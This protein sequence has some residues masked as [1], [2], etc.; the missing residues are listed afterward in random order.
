MTTPGHPA[1]C[2]SVA[3]F[4]EPTASDGLRSRYPGDRLLC[5]ACAG[6][7]PWLAHEP[8]ARSRGARAG[9]ARG[10]LASCGGG[11]RSFV[12]LAPVVG[13]SRLD[14]SQRGA[15]SEHL[16]PGPDDVLGGDVVGEVVELDTDEASSPELSAEPLGGVQRRVR[17]SWRRGSR[18]RSSRDHSGDP[19]RSAP[20]CLPGTGGGAHRGCSCAREAEEPILR[21]TVARV[22]TVE[23]AAEAAGIPV[24]QLVLT[25]RRAAGSSTR[26]LRM[27][28]PL[29]S[30]SWR[31]QRTQQIGVAWLSWRSTHPGGERWGSRSPAAIHPAE[32]RGGT[33]WALAGARR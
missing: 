29:A 21:R 14:R 33:W 12:P 25:L 7:S 30:S 6:L 17:A 10:A 24:R 16:V 9:A 27:D 22:A 13:G 3:L 19:R 15:L 23:R 1:P 18:R 28:R 5:Y 26:L 32:V 31:T 2:G 20:R 11:G 8:P 4:V